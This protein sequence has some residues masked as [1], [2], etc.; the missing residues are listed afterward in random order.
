MK[1]NMIII[2]TIAISLVL[3]GCAGKDTKPMSEETKETVED[4]E[5]KKTEGLANPWKYGVTAEDVKNLVNS[6]FPVPDGASEVSYGIMESEKLAEMDFVLNGKHYTARMEPSKEFKDISGLYYEWDAEGVDIINGAEAQIRVA[7]VDNISNILWNDGE[8]MYSV[9]TPYGDRDGHDLMAVVKGMY[10]PAEAAETEKTDTGD[11]DMYGY[12]VDKLPTDKYYN[13]YNVKG[14]NDEI[15]ICNYNG[16]DELKE[17]TY[18]G[19]WQIGDGWTL[20]VIDDDGNSTA[21]KA[22]ITDENGITVTDMELTIN[23]PETCCFEFSLNNPGG[24]DLTFDIT[25]I[26]LENYDGTKL[27]PFGKEN[28]PLDASAKTERHSYT[29]DV[30]NLKNGDEVSVYY[31]DKYVTSIFVKGGPVSTMDDTEEIENY[32]AGVDLDEYT[33]MV[34]EKAREAEEK[35]P[36]VLEKKDS[37]KDVNP[38]ESGLFITSDKVECRSLKLSCHGNVF[39]FGMELYNDTGSDKTFDQ[40]KFVIEKGE[41]VYVNPF[42]FEEVRE[43]EVVKGDTKR[44]WM[45]YTIYNPK[46]LKIGDEVSVYYDGVFITKLTVEK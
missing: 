28:K 27:D 17:G 5:A 2:S 12:V 6:E 31:D 19:M 32:F 43:P 7:F 16:N 41:G 46:D 13:H 45:A 23:T 11:Y 15:F 40:T 3:F 29:M 30:G 10:D 44:L 25:K 22:V 18:V 26:R 21:E 42:V 14:D 33:R 8:M 36:V 4:T 24:R 20:E 39:S 35:N 37:S 34:M 9:Y 38:V 1:K